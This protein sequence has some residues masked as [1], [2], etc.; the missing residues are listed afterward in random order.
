MKEHAAMRTHPRHS[1]AGFSL[2]EVLIAIAIL[3]FGIAAVI[4]MFP[5][6]LTNTQQAAQR[7]VVAELAETSLNRLRTAG[8][9]HVWD[10][11][12]RLRGIYEMYLI[13]G[14]VGRFETAGNLYDNY[15]TQVTPMRGA[16][17][18]YL[19]RITF[20]VEMPDERKRTFVTYVSEQ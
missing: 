15:W 3:L 9:E 16:Q 2:V 5:L 17:G 11:V 7:T 18:T 20:T 12:T 14:T 19:Q 10:T 13:D 1:Q 8:A 4:R 6:S